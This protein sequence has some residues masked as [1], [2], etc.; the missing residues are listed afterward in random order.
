MVKLNL[1]VF[2]VRKVKS[3]L[4]ATIILSLLYLVGQQASHRT[5]RDKIAAIVESHRGVVIFLKSHTARD[6]EFRQALKQ[7]KPRLKGKAEI[8]VLSQDKPPSEPGQ[9]VP[10]L[11]PILV[12][13]DAHGIERQRFEGTVDQ[14]KLE[15]VLD[16]WIIQHR[17]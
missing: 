6:R 1:S 10:K 9:P 13:L 17:H 11:N 7:I 5:P 3:L 12:I 2:R 15:E 4:F 14:K 8:M 16:V